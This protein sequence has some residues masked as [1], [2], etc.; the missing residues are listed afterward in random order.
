MRS[1]EDP[2]NL[3]DL[4]PGFE[5]MRARRK[6]MPLSDGLVR[7]APHYVVNESVLQPHERKSR[8]DLEILK[9]ANEVASLGTETPDIYWIWMEQNISA[10]ELEPDSGEMRA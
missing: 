4:T 7:A 10:S 6:R 9:G 3:A 2:H 1:G 5:A 8:D